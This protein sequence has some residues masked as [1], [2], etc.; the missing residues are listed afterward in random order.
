[1]T[2]RFSGNDSRQ[3]ARCATVRTRAASC[4]SSNGAPR[5]SNRANL[6][7]C[8][9]VRVMTKQRRVYRLGGSSLF[10][11]ARRK[12]IPFLYLRTVAF[13]NAKVSRSKLKAAAKLLLCVSA[14]R[15]PIR[16]ICANTRRSLR[17]ISRTGRGS[18]AFAFGEIAQS[19]KF[20]VAFLEQLFDWRF[21]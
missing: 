7:N 11:L 4:L 15:T 5:G 10:D 17:I 16:N 9:T 19:P 21:N 6:R 2:R 12:G 8:I 20:F 13:W 3:G 1:M 18:C 14:T